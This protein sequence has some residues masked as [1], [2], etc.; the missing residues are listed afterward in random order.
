MKNKFTL[1]VILALLLE[2]YAFSYA[3]TEEA[4]NIRGSFITAVE[5]ELKSLQSWGLRS[6]NSPEREIKYWEFDKTWNTF[7]S[8]WSNKYS[9]DIRKTNSLVSPYVGIVTFYGQ[10]YRKT[11]K[12]KEECLKA[13]WKPMDVPSHPTL[14]FLYQDGSWILYE[15]PRAYKKYH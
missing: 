7:Y 11:G 13:P 15:A 4:K 10:D 8:K 3:Q 1:I 14:K 6:K 5:R 9:Y 12:S 2:S